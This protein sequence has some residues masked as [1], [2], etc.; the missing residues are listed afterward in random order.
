MNLN[1]SERYGTLYSMK[2]FSVILLLIF[3]P[4][5]VY[6]LKEAYENSDEDYYLYGALFT[7]MSICSVL[8]LVNG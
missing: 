2:L 4:A 8:Y 1:N 3:A 7:I 5:A 6:Y